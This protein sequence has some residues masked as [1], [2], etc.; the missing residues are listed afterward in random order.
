MRYR[1]WDGC[2]HRPTR[3]PE[4]FP[5]AQPVSFSRSHLNLLQREDYYVCEKSDGVRYLLYFTAPYGRH[6]AYL[7]DRNYVVRELPGWRI[8]TRTGSWHED[9]L[10][11]GELIYE[12]TTTPTDANDRTTLSSDDAK[13]AGDEEEEKE[14]DDDRASPNDE[15][16]ASPPLPQAKGKFV[17]LI[18][19]IL[20]AN[21]VNVMNAP[22]PSRLKHVQNDIILVQP[23]KEGADA[24]HSSPTSL[25]SPCELRLKKM[26][27]SYAIAEILDL[28]IPRQMHGNDGLIF[29]PVSQPYQSGTCERLLKWKPS[30][31]NSVDFK[32]TV[33]PA[34][35]HGSPPASEV[36]GRHPGQGSKFELHVA[37]TRGD[38]RFFT[39]IVPRSDEEATLFHSLADQ[40]IECRPM[41]RKTTTTMATGAASDDPSTLQW[42]F[43]K[44][45]R[46]KVQ[47]N[48]ERVVTKIIASIR[49][50]VTKEELFR[51]IPAIRTAWKSREQAVAA[52]TSLNPVTLKR[53]HP[54]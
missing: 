37:T 1:L 35:Q 3:S 49:D 52:A 33:V 32:L 39:D 41:E 34:D 9:T 54:D 20:L 15:S 48:N 5:G 45:R 53:P 23:S 31:L 21:G 38:H 46:D 19:D 10:L 40:I 36:N 43:L 8:P 24:A 18:F 29:T 27:K 14:K 47:A 44:A 6:T 25:P 50:N 42:E 7:I 26:W 16:N 17:F 11:D 4:I 12:P 22:L 30:E 28:E 51:A 2:L 13:V